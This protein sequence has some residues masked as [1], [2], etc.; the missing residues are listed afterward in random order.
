MH[1][2]ALSSLFLGL[3]ITKSPVT[4][5]FFYAFVPV[6]FALS[7]NKSILKPRFD[8]VI[9]VQL[10]YLSLH[11]LSAFNL[12]FQN[13]L[14]ECI[15]VFVV[16]VYYYLFTSY[17]IIYSSRSFVKY[18]Y[19]FLLSIA[20]FT[21][22]WHLANGHYV[23]WK[24]LDAPKGVFSFMVVI[25]MVTFNIFGIRNS[26]YGLV[27]SAVLVM[28]SAER[29]AFIQLPFGPLLLYG[30]RSY[31]LMFSLVAIVISIFMLYA[32]FEVPMVVR[33]VDS[34]LFYSAD[35][36]VVD[37]ATEGLSEG[38]VSI[39]NL[40]RQFAFEIGMELLRESPVF[41]IGTNA[42]KDYVDTY[43]SDMPAFL[44]PNIH[45]EFFRTLFEL[46][47]VGISLYSFL[48]LAALWRILSR[49]EVK[50]YFNGFRYHHWLRAMLWISMLSIVAFEASNMLS[51]LLFLMAPHL[52]TIIRPEVVGEWKIQRKRTPSAASAAAL[53]PHPGPRI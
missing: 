38:G 37:V 31:K 45:G 25:V 14:R 19:I 15:Q 11:G 24:D 53:F 35:D 29:K 21:I 42:Y 51:M 5:G 47:I 10:L 28:L 41:G 6:I 2:A 26:M 48:W 20:V 36:D 18:S 1:A 50:E 33:Q 46:G 12:D 7:L 27:L 3:V 8:V 40:Q 44:R 52:T 4:I 22:G 39:S 32:V 30:V 34:V 13:G 43:L 16:I 49:V 9:V 17:I 23:R